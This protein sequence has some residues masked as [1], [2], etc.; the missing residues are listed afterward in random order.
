METD[1]WNASYRNKF[2]KKKQALNSKQKIEMDAL[3]VK[4]Q[5]SLQEKLRMRS[6]ELQKYH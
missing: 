6:A 4:L 3:K 5:N 2:L 1:K